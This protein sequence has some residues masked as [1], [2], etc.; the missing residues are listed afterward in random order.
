M[1]TPSIPSTRSARA[2]FVLLAVGAAAL[3][4]GRPALAAGGCSVASAPV[5]APGT[6]AQV[7]QNAC[8]DHYEYWAMNLRIGD[9]LTV[10]T[11][12]GGSDTAELGVYGPNVGTIGGTPLCQATLFEPAEAFCLIAANGRYVLAFDGADVSFT[13]RVK[14]V[15]AARGRVAGACDAASAPSIAS[16]TTQ[17]ASAKLCA[18]S[19]S[20]QYW[21]VRL[22][23]G[24]RLGVDVDTL[25]QHPD[26][27][28]LLAVFG[29]TSGTDGGKPRCSTPEFD[30]TSRATC[31]IRAGG[32]YIIVSEI[33]VAIS[34]TPRIVHHTSITRGVVIDTG[35][36]E[37]VDA[38]VKSPAPHPTGT[39]LLERK[40]AG[41]WTV[42][43]TK[44]TKTGRCSL[45]ARLPRVHHARTAFRVRFRGALGWAGSSTR[46]FTL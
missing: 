27:Q 20:S 23:R 39:C 22:Y 9:K 43:A 25:D 42:T 28:A 4:G 34:F 26:D 41:H 31:S 17:Y 16:G 38:V 7:D 2:V 30:K 14:S 11:T 29:P 6:T 8:P 44:R 12:A 46:P 40:A 37:I 1:T 10:D 33:G 19:G 13:A 35:S 18:A 15:R 24:D 21:A 36:G 3:L 5:I 45:R 32:R